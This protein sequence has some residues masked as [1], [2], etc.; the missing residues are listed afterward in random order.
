MAIKLFRSHAEERRFALIQSQT[1]NKICMPDAIIKS[2]H[3]SN[4]IPQSETNSSVI[5]GSDM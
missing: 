4:D 3:A 2:F 5:P 1:H